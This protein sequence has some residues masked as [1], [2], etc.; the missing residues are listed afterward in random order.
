MLGLYVSMK[1]I[2]RLFVQLQ[3]QPVRV[4]EKREPPPRKLI[5]AHRLADDTMRP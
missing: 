2:S 1:A 3:R 5:D 4:T